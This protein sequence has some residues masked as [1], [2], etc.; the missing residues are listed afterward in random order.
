MKKFG[1][2]LLVILVVAIIA[3]MATRNA[4]IKNVIEKGVNE[5]VGQKITVGNVD[6][7]IFETKIKFGRLEVY[8]PSGYTDKLLADIHELYINYALMDIINGFIHLPELKIDIK[9]MN[10]EKDKKGVLNLE[11][12]KGKEGEAKPEAKKEEKKKFLINKMD[13]EIDTIRYRDNTKTPPELKKLEINFKKTFN[14]IDS[15]E[16]IINEIK[17]AAVQQLVERGIKVA[18]E[19]I[20]KDDKLQKALM[21]GDTK[22]VEKEGAFDLEKIGEGLFGKKK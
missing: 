20:L 12:F 6:V 11:H 1:L 13:L 10:V 14:N 18:L 21:G 3:A 8:N 5:A 22:T 7:G 15:A 19:T 4:I 9:E 16:V 2:I 17:N